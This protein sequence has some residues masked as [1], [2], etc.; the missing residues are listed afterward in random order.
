MFQVCRPL[1]AS[2]GRALGTAH[3]TA[4]LVLGPA[5]IRFEVCTL[6]EARPGASLSL[7]VDTGPQCLD[8]LGVGFLRGTVGVTRVESGLLVQ[9][10]V[11]SQLRIQCVRCLD[12]FDLPVNLELEETFRLPGSSPRPGMTYAVSSNGWLDLVPLL[13]EASWLAIPLKPVCGA[14]CKGICSRCGANLNSG[15]CECEDAEVDPRWAALRD[16]VL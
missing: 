1:M 15:T 5:M 12:S 14:G 6:V 10:T 7:N 11:A 4:V 2:L 8:D 9:G 3:R 13:R 16:L